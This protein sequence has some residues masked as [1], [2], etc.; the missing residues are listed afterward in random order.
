MGEVL[1]LVQLHLDH[2]PVDDS[3][4]TG[5]SCLYDHVGPDPSR[6]RFLGTQ[7]VASHLLAGS[8]DREEGWPPFVVKRNLE[9]TPS[10]GPS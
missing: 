5:R 4:G 7:H 9:R 6:H 10:F 2:D 1:A 8:V 3:T